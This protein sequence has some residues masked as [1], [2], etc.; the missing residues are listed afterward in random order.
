MTA[1]KKYGPKKGVTMKSNLDS[2]NDTIVDIKDA[3]TTLTDELDTLEGYLADIE[4]E[5]ACME[6][7]IK[8]AEEESKN[9]SKLLVLVHGLLNASPPEFAAR[10]LEAHKALQDFMEGCDDNV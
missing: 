5:L 6:E 1:S 9:H 2:A 3:I 7:V 10:F 8:G 4:N